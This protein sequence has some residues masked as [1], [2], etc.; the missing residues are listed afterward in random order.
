VAAARHRLLYDADCGLC[1]WTLAWVLRWDRRRAI[2]PVALQDRL[3]AE[4]LA[5]VAEE[6]RMASWHLVEPDGEV[7]SAGAAVAPLLRLLPGGGP[8]A[9]PASRFQ[10]AVDLAYDWVAGHR[11]ALGRPLTRGAIA[12]ADRVIESRTSQPA[13]AR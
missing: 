4:L 2:V 13:S 11:G 10:R 7:V 1:R 9:A 12:R 6:K 3:A 8:L 5:D